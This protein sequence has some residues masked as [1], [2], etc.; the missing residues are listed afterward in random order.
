MFGQDIGDR[1]HKRRSSWWLTSNRISNGK[2]VV[3]VLV[4]GVDISGLKFT[5]WNLLGEEDVEFV[6]G[7]VLGLWKS[8]V[9]PDEHKPGTP[10]PDKAGVTLQVPSIWIH[11]IVFKSSTDDT[12]NVGG[13]S[14]KADS[15]LSETSRADFGGE[16]PTK[17]TS[18][19]LESESPDQRQNGLNPSNITAFGP[20]VENSNKAKLYCHEEHAPHVNCSSTEVRHE[21]EP[22]A[23]TGEE[24]E[25]VG[26]PAEGVSCSVA[27][28]DLLE[29]ISA[30]IGEA[31]TAD[32]LTSK[33]DDRDF[34][35]SKFE[36]FEAIPVSCADGQ[37]LFEIVGID[38]LGQN[39][40]WV[41]TESWVL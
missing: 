20:W 17:L 18:R 14:S 10:T 36:A 5:C 7:S 40:L 23:E 27:Q 1:R 3:V 21:E 35:S 16:S 12:R 38:D 9:C 22:V 11:E 24:S 33:D 13:V 4:K 34:C 19:E 41:R 2:L 37:L 31:K 39:L 8:E 30:S 25:S 26:T 28:A 6:E 32:E 29:E 15:L